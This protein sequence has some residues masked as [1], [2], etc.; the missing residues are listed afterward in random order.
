MFAPRLL[1]LRSPI[2]CEILP[3]S[4]HILIIMYCML[5]CITTVYVICNDMRWN[6]FL[7]SIIMSLILNIA[8]C[9]L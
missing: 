9:N 3:P 5:V 7:L 6:F 8:M 4:G 1:Y 2:I